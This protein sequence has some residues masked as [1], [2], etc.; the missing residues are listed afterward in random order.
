MNITKG[1][2][3]ILIRDFFKEISDSGIS[4]IPNVTRRSIIV[5]NQYSLVSKDEIMGVI[6]SNPLMITSSLIA[7]NNE[8][9]DCD[10]YAL[11]LKALITALYRQRFLSGNA[12]LF[13]PAIGIVIT[14]SHAINLII[15]KSQNGRPILSL[16]DPSESSP[17]FLDNPSQSLQALK[18]L[19]VAMIYI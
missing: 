2:I 10:D 3:P 5:D 8:L 13:P 6:K 18:T 9:F 17:A 7:G 12:A 15:T 16:I 4:S 19:P 14:Q 1:K 11:Q